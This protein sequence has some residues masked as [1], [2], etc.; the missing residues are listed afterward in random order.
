MVINACKSNLL[1][2]A[3]AIEASE[4][5]DTGALIYAAMYV[6]NLKNYKKYERN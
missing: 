2:L 1:S 3:T 6:E 4:A 5:N